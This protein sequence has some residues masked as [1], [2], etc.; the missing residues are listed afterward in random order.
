MPS[1]AVKGWSLTELIP[2]L[3][4]VFAHRVNRHGTVGRDW[5]K[6][7]Y[8]VIQS[9]SS[10]VRNAAAQHYSS[11]PFRTVARLYQAL[12]DPQGSND[13]AMAR[14]RIE[15]CAIVFIQHVTIHGPFPL[16]SRQLMWPLQ[17]FALAMQQEEVVEQQFKQQGHHTDPIER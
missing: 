7:W 3:Q 8:K 10:H 9:A 5:D 4:R 1:N 12:V 17:E 2:F 6:A 15:S 14:M 13:P 16:H 11:T